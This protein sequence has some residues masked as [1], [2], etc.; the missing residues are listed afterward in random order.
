[1][2]KIAYSADVRVLDDKIAE[3]GELNST[4]ENVGFAI[5]RV[6]LKM[7]GGSYGKRVLIDAGP[8]N[9][10][11]DAKAAAFQLE[12]R[13]VKVV[14]KGLTDRSMSDV[15]GVDLYIDGVFGV[16]IGRDYTPRTVPDSIPV[17][18]IDVPSGLNPDLGT[19]HGGCQRADVT[20][21]V[22]ALKPGLLQNQG[23]QFAGK[24]ELVL[25]DLYQDELPLALIEDSDV[26]DLLPASNPQDHKW[27]HSV[28][29]LAGSE[30]MMGAAELAA[31]ASYRIASG[32]V[33]LYYPI[34]SSGV[35]SVTLS[36]EIV[37]V[38]LESL[39]AE[40]VI[41]SAK[42]FKA[43]V[44]G[45]GLGRSLQ[46]SNLIRRLLSHSEI[47]AVL[48]A[49]G[50]F[51]MGEPARLERVTQGRRAP[52]VITPHEGEFNAFFESTGLVVKSGA[53]RVALT[54]QAAL[55]TGSIVL[56]K[57]APTIVATPQGVTYVVSSGSSRLAVAGTGDVL[58]GIIGGL[59]ARG[60]EPAYAAALGAHIHGRASCH[61]GGYSI[62]ASDLID[63]C[64]KWLSSLNKRWHVD[65][66][67][68]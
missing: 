8:G 23:P 41:E 11:A 13:G 15:E 38:G 22:G 44:I 26:I 59:L 24:V 52:I 50:L 31:L 19:I 33:H 32:I 37:R 10:G 51:A 25:S 18:A 49:D 62:R 55:I 66:E 36:P 4:I 40:P 45:P 27:S 21:T 5:S 57:G 53:D 6:A 3:R 43:I 39:W 68:I 47:P 42:R 1:M 54:R 61:L 48:D 29:A 56:L 58:S 63:A 34:F 28:F 46:L 7:L 64:S 17:L 16:G 65:S 12:K 20:V 35:P 30:S 60:V 14:V 2:K 9:N 67:S